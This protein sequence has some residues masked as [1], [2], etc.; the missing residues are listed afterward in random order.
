MDLNTKIT[1]N[2]GIEIPVLGLGVWKTSNKDATNSV[3]LAVK[4]GYRLI[5]TAKQYGNEAGVGQGIT[6]A[7]KENNLKREDI[8]LTTKVFNG[9]QGYNS[10][11]DSINEQLKR[12]Q[13]SYIDLLLIHWPVFDKYLET[14]RALEE[15]YKQ[16]KIRAIGVSNFDIEKL[17]TILNNFKTVPVINQMEF[18]PHCQEKDILKFCLNH[19]IQ[20]E[21][22]S[23]LGGG[24]LLKD[25]VINNLAKKYHKTPA[26][27]ILRWDIQKRVLPIPKSIH[28]KRIIE[29]SNI[30]D[31]ELANEDMNNINNLDQNNRSLW[32]EDFYWS[33]NKRGFKDSIANIK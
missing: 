8:F 29:N 13:T 2:N 24:D 22:W 28:E 14:Y 3:K 5:D 6:E 30:F 31:F 25:S 20:L 15:L 18:H 21:A 27:I 16:G 10:T 12:L 1:L 4:N 7:L 23:P 17:T 11:L 32:Y 26:Q 33:G 9:D 19:N